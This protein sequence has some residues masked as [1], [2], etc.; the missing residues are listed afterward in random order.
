MTT[1]FAFF[2]SPYGVPL[3]PYIGII[4]MT[5]VIVLGISFLFFRA[6]KK[7]APKGSIS[8]ITGFVEDCASLYLKSQYALV[9]KVLLLFSG[10]MFLGSFLDHFN[11]FFGLALFS[12]GL[13]AAAIGYF[14]LKF[15]I[16][17]AA[18]VVEKIQQK[19][20][21]GTQLLF[22]A[23]G[24]MVVLCATIVLADMFVW[25]LLLNLVFD[26]NFFN[27]GIHIVHKVGMGQN[28]T[29]EM[30][31]NPEFIRFK[32]EEIALILLSYTIGASLYALIGRISG[33]VL[34]QSTHAAVDNA[35]SQTEFTL[36]D[37]DIRNPGI[38]ADLIAR[39][40]NGIAGGLA[41]LYQLLAIGLALAMYLGAFIIE[42]ISITQGILAFLFPFLV[43]GVGIVSALV[44]FFYLSRTQK[45]DA[46]FRGQCI[47]SGIGIVLFLV[48]ILE[49]SFKFEFIL[50]AIVGILASSIIGIGIRR[51]TAINGRPVT[52]VIDSGHSGFGAMLLKGIELGFTCALIPILVTL[53]ALCVAYFLGNGLHE[54]VTGMY[55]V[56]L[57]AIASIG[58]GLYLYGI[59]TAEPIASTGL[60]LARM[61]QDETATQQLQELE[62]TTSSARVAS[63]AGFGMALTLIVATTITA[64]LIS[65]QHWIHKLAGIEGIGIGNTYFSNHPLA[66]HPNAIIISETHIFDL[67]DLL[68]VSMINPQFIAGLILGLGT[69]IWIAGRCIRQANTSA[70][71]IATMIRVEFTE[72]PDISTGVALPNYGNSI[73]FSTAFSQKSVLSPVL[74]TCVSVTLASIA[75]GLAGSIGHIFGSLMGLLVI[76]LTAGSATV[77][78]RNAYIQ[79][80]KS[81]DKLKASVAALKTLG[82]AGAVVPDCVGPILNTVMILMI[83]L[84]LLLGLVGLKFGHI[85]VL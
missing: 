64:I 66:A 6:Q 28:W 65:I 14:T 47:T 19:E 36:P 15:S 51:F 59:A 24:M 35:F 44:G 20:A 39:N 58:Q 76:T 4:F 77:F 53:S 78:W 81:P 1:P 85:L 38:M 52:A 84:A 23:A 57:C 30:A 72:N 43:L 3:P 74:F 45:K 48:M 71:H 7:D 17:L 73:S 80:Q 22:T 29:P 26:H 8:E 41:G 68:G 49:N 46:I 63:D 55:A 12:G 34:R 79:L 61:L 60:A 56:M 21:A 13:W 27:L 62:A 42:A 32:F 37:D 18:K 82:S 70:D 50:A 2:S 67:A 40:A 83:S 11:H 31:G 16:S 25:V 9:A 69:I 54:L 75:F 5:I 33:G 10:L